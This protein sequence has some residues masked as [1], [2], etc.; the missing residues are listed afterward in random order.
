MSLLGEWTGT[1][2]SSGTRGN[3]QIEVRV[4]EFA[5][6]PVV[7]IL[8]DNPCILP[9]S[10]EFSL[11]SAGIEL[12][13]EGQTVLRAAFGPNRTMTGEYWCPQ[14]SGSWDAAWQQEL[15]EILDLSGT[16]NGTFE[17][18]GPA[19]EVMELELSQEVTGG[20]V[21]LIGAATFPG[22]LP[23]PL[24]VIGAAR[25]RSDAFDIVLDTTTGVLPELQLLGVGDSLTA[26][27]EGVLVATGG[28]LPATGAWQLVR[29]PR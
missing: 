10:Y 6:S 5:D 21:R 9:R 22:M 3:G 26:A 19:P 28:S 12:T 17:F 23:A 1:W 2:A 7:T 27:L 18:G 16:W 4:Q 25:F 13:A 11:S 15:P 24:P 20:G 29:S 14:D 8:I